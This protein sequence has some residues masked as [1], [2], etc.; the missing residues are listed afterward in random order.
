MKMEL[1]I[2]T[3]Q[4][5]ENL[6]SKEVQELIKKKSKV[7]P[8]LVYLEADE[9]ESIQLIHHLQSSRRILFSLGSFTDLNKLSFKDTNWKDLLFPNISLSII[10]EG[11]KGQENRNK[12]I[13]QVAGQLL[14]FLEK[15][16]NLVCLILHLNLFLKSIFQQY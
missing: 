8:S 3:N 7:Y 12:I 1:I 15:D 2:L 11:V 6:A 13:G 16:D 4:G 10:V 5:L 14:P 9:K